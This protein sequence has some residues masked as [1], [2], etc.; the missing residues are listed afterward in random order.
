MIREDEEYLVSIGQN[1]RDLN[2]LSS[3]DEDTFN[4]Q[5]QPLKQF[6]NE[7]L[8]VDDSEINLLAIQGIFDQLLVDKKVDTATDG[9]SAIE[10]VRERL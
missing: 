4:N 1:K 8:V 2:Q 7:V 6:E 5:N 3:T 9:E 10:L